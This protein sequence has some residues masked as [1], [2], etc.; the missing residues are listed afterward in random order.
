MFILKN[1]NQRYLNPFK[2]VYTP[3][4]SSSSLNNQQYFSLFNK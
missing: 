3:F 4:S 1:L 2:V